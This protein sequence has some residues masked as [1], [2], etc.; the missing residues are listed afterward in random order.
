MRDF[1]I[2][3]IDDST[4]ERL[5]ER[6]KENGRSLQSEARLILQEASRRGAQDVKALMDK[7]RARWKGKPLMGDSVDLIREDRD[8]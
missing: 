2:R 1:L 3:G 7:W 8:R 4:L 6:A 5:K